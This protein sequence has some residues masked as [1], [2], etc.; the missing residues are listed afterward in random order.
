MDKEISNEFMK[1]LK[2]QGLKFH[3]QHKVEKIKKNNNGA[4][5]KTID[6]NGKKNNFDL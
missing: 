5:I 1:I 2:K 6:K 3:L 4:I